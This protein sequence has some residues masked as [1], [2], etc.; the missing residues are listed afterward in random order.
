MKKVN[1]NLSEKQVDKLKEIS[2]ISGI[3]YSEHVRRAI[4]EYLRKYWQQYQAE[5][6]DKGKHEKE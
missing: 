4:D 5:R 2:G 6:G 3:S 1:L